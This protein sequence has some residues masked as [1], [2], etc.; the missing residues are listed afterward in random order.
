MKEIEQFLS[1]GVENVFPSKES[2]AT[3]L[4][5]GKKLS[6]YLGIDPT[7]PSLHIGHAIPLLKLSKLQKMGHRVILLM[8]DFTAM[9][10]DPSDKS[11]VRKQLTRKEVLANL[12]TVSIFNQERLIIWENPSEDILKDFPYLYPIPSGG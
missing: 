11:A 9:I 7:G 8:G 1:R 5:S 4:A 3:A 6:I 12:Q 10:G 2:F